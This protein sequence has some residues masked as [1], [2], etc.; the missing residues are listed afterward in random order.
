MSRSK[1]HMEGLRSC[2][3]SYR[4]RRSFVTGIT[5]RAELQEVLKV[6]RV[7]LSDNFIFSVKKGNY[8]LRR[9]GREDTGQSLGAKPG[10]PG[11]IRNTMLH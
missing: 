6:G 3:R 9:R 8:H 5:R 4:G 2:T 11:F 7:F 10:R 1:G